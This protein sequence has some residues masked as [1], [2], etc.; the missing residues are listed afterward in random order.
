[1]KEWHHHLT[2]LNIHR[3]WSRTVFQKYGKFQI[4]INFLI[5]YPIFMIIV[6]FCRNIF[7]F[8]WNEDN[9]G[10]DFL[11]RDINLTALL[12]NSKNSQTELP[13]L[14]IW[15]KKQPRNWQELSISGNVTHSLSL[16]RYQWIN[17]IYCSYHNLLQHSSLRRWYFWFSLF[18]ST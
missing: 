8:L 11:F 5:S 12:T 2:L 9:F 10:L 6:P 1:M 17:C 3:D 13:D 16:S 4:S 14:C 15:K 18:R 7:L